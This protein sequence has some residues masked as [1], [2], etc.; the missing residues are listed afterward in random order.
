VAAIAWDGGKESTRAVRTA[1][2]L[3]EKASKVVIL[4]AP[5]EAPRPYDPARLQAFLTA[6][7]VKSE[8]MALKANGEVAPLLLSTAKSIGA[9]LM[10]AGAFG[11]PRLQEFVFGGATRSFLHADGPSLFL[12]H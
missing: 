4:A 10:I 12:S 6:R 11:H 3:L 9:E 7:G 2:P 8:I 1:L 5:T